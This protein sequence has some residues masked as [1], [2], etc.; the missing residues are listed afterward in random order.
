MYLNCHTFHSLRYGTLS[1]EDLVNTAKINGVDTL[2]LTDINTVT[3]IYEFLKLCKEVE[4]KPIVGMEVRHDN[5]LLYILLAKNAKGIAEINQLLTDHNCG[6]IPLPECNPAF[7]HVIILYPMENVPE[8]LSDN[9]Y[10]GIRPEQLNLLFRSEWKRLLDRM[11]ILQPVTFNRKKEYNLHRVLRAIDY[12][13]L[14][15]KLLPQQYCTPDEVIKPLPVLLKFYEHYPE[16]VA[17]TQYVI[18]ACSFD[19][20]FSTPKNKK[21]YTDS[22]AN[23]LELLTRLT[24]EGLKKKYDPNDQAAIQRA[25]K[26]LKVIDELNFSGYFLITWDIVQYS[27]S[28]GLM[29]IGR[30]SGANSIISYC[31]GI[32]DICPIELDLYFERF[33]NL[34][35]KTPPDFDIDWSWQDRDTILEYIFKKY[36]KNHVAFCGT[37]VEF[38]YRSIFREVGKVF[39]LPKE[40]LDMLA[41]QPIEMHDNNSVVQQVY[42]YGKMMEK[43]PNQRSM[44]ACGILISEEPITTYSALEMP[45]KGF[46]I[47]QFDMHVAEDIGLEKFDILSQRGIGHINDTAK[48]I[49]KNRGIDVDIRD[50]RLSKDEKLCNEFLSKGHTIGCFYIESPAM[51]GLLRRLKCDN[52][53]VL[54]AASSIIR[55]GVAQSGMMKEYIFRHNHPDQFEYFHPVFEEQLGETYGIMVYQEDV[56]KIALHYGGLSAPDGDILRRAMSGKGRS[57]S[58]LQRV[59]DHFF[60]S[61]AQLGHPE[62]LSTE[63]YRQIESF[64]G[65][66]F[67]KAHSASYAVES[68]QS[69]YLK[70]YY[71]VEFMVAVINNQGG[72]YRTEVYVHEAKMSGANILPPCVNKS[73][74]ETTLF[75]IDVYMG[76]MHLQSLET[77]TAQLIVQERNRNGDYRSLEDF[78]KRIPVGIAT[79]QILIFIGAFRFTGYPKNELLLKAR[80]LLNDFKPEQRFQVLFEEPIK[81]YELPVLK[82]DKFEDA[83]DEIE[84][85]GFPITCSPFDLLQTRYRG[86][87]MASELV[88]YH[89][90][91]VKMLAYLISRKHVPTKRGVMYFGTW[92]DAEGEYF[93][94]AHFPD[95]LAKYPFQGGGCYL[96]LGTVEVDYHFPTIT[97]I[98]MAKMPFIPDPRYAYNEQKRYEAHQRIKEDVS[99]THRKPYPQEHEIGLPRKKLIG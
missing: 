71:P 67:C 44:H 30:G 87:V 66:S 29:H 24:Y 13:T 35:R 92:I 51:R 16:I 86:S 56:I 46:P 4:I 10:I 72:F 20:D 18:D 52:Y 9:E 96:L 57:L 39:G 15:S 6:G 31:L 23:D 62:A 64:A 99:M 65:Y 98:K 85:L 21:Y 1:V 80:M 53:K 48:L 79:I 3:A 58:A 76:F 33:L 49:K 88:K 89:K 68:Y 43:F 11:V 7:Q 93:D 25:E 27:N 19:F 40:E 94:T 5:K 83:F 63:V 34:N 17:N 55:P 22:K 70:V 37:N 36:G 84:L 78:I 73:E 47:V 8:V 45:P 97:I 90:K 77:R 2:C 32:T 60:E 82:R 75:G 69:L 81:E 14:I 61:C 26:E 54:V 28:L 74:H 12:N 50:T 95:S 59:K 41:T 38:K 91:E 42:R